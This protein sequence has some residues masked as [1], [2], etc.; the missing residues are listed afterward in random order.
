ML[1]ILPAG[2]ACEEPDLPPSWRSLESVDGLREV[3]G[4]G[5]AVVR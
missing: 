2:R 4:G 5:A 1:D 3:G